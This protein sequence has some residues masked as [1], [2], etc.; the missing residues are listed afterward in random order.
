MAAFESWAGPAGACAFFGAGA[1][2][3]ISSRWRMASECESLPLALA[4][5]SI[6][7]A[8]SGVIRSVFTGAFLIT[9]R[10]VFLRISDFDFAIIASGHAGDFTSELGWN[11]RR[12]CRAAE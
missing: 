1:L 12:G 6:R 9:G 11:R 4:H 3:A 2:R 8:R 5:A 7:R 10:P